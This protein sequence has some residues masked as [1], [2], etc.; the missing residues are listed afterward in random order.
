MNYSP[1][2]YA[3][4]ANEL[5]GFGRF[6]DT[7]MVHMNPLEVAMMD[8][9]VPG[10]LTRNPHTGKPEAFLPLLIPVLLGAA[11]SGG[12][13]AAQGA[14]WKKALKS[15]A[16]G[17][18]TSFVTAGLGSMLSPASTV[19]TSGLESAIQPGIGDALRDSIVNTVKDPIQTGIESALPIDLGTNAALDSLGNLGTGATGATGSG[20]GTAGLGGAL[21]DTG[22]LVTSPADPFGGGPV[23]PMADSPVPS[24]GPIASG[25]AVPEQAPSFLE[26]LNEGIGSAFDQAKEY[27]TQFKDSV[28]D[29]LTEKAPV[30]EEGMSDYL[31]LREAQDYFGNPVHPFAAV[32]ASEL[33][34]PEPR[35]KYGSVPWPETTSWSN[36]G[37]GGG[38]GTSWSNW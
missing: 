15:A 18:A 32:T 7:T 35:E 38:S 28:G 1:K 36:Y 5:S 22:G 19:A 13:A 33:L 14:D 4:V 25:P 12:S 2:P 16:I 17:G 9:Y 24:A 11:L 8:Q 31:R 29:Y 26:N 3:N 23:P 30:S 21:P 27:G 34:T 20:G 10:G 6:G 37:S